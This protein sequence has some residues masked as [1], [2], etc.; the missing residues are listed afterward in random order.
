MFDSPFTPWFPSDD[1]GFDLLSCLL[2]LLAFNPP[3]SPG[4]GSSAPSD[5]VSSRKD[6]KQR[7]LADTLSMNFQENTSLNH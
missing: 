2:L 7:L 1:P 4:Q 3:P 6:T 5:K